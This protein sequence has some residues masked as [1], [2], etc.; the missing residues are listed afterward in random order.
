MAPVTKKSIIEDHFTHPGHTLT[1]IDSDQEYLCD[2]CKTMGSGKRYRCV[3]GCDFDLHE[4]CR[5]CPRKLS[6]FMHQHELRLVMRKAESQRQV[7]RVCNV[8]LDPVEGLFYRCKGCEFDVHP[9]CTQLPQQLHH[10][11]H[12]VHFLTLKSSKSPGFCAVCKAACSG[13]RYRCG[14]CNFDIHLECVLV[15]TVPCPQQDGAAGMKQRGI[16]MFDHGIPYQPPPQFASYFGYGFPYY[17]HPGYQYQPG[18]MMQPAV[19]QHGI[20]NFGQQTHQVA[21]ASGGSRPR[22]SMFSLVG[23]LGFGVLSNMIFGVDLTSLFVAAS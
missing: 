16:P 17:V 14:A 11:L 1:P 19:Y 23:Q 9:L 20:Y 2:G 15:P 18:F 6:N 8:C 22:K 21:G 12:K 4:Y 10:A 5:T 13:W 3:V 7:D